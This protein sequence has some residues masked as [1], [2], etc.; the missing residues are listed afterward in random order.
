MPTIPT[1]YERRV[2]EGRVRT[3]SEQASKGLAW[4]R[5]DFDTCQTSP[6]SVERD[7]SIT[8]SDCSRGGQ[9]HTCSRTYLRQ[10][11]GLHYSVGQVP[12]FALGEGSDDSDGGVGRRARLPNLRERQVSPAKPKKPKFS[13]AID[14]TDTPSMAPSAKE[15]S[16]AE[17][18]CKNILQ[19]YRRWRTVG[20]FRCFNIEW[21]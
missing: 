5:V 8:G 10:V 11:C 12:F 4:Q 15:T 20:A 17:A 3:V 13:D 9:R 19:T 7:V 16:K 2:V 18:T 14:V 21:P 1:C 6:E